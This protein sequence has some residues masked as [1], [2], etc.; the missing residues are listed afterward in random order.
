MSIAQIMDARREAALQ[1][2]LGDALR[3]HV[4]SAN[5]RKK[6]TRTSCEASSPR[7]APRGELPA[8]RHV[9]E[10]PAASS[11]KVRT[12][13]ASWDDAEARWEDAQSALRWEASR[14]SHDKG[15]LRYDDPHGLSGRVIVE[16]ELWTS[17]SD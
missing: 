2:R 12:R 9:G 10:L 16:C 8:A 15:S 6:R 14:A 7:R 17:G 3:E 4:G 1:N 13:T 5:R 11:Q